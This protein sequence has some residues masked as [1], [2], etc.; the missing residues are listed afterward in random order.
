MPSLDVSNLLDTWLEEAEDE[1]HNLGRMRT[2]TIATLFGARL[3]TEPDL[4]SSRPWWDILYDVPHPV[5]EP[6]QAPRQAFIVGRSLAKNLLPAIQ[7][8]NFMF[9]EWCAAAKTR[10]QTAGSPPFDVLE[11]DRCVRVIDDLDRLSRV[12]PYFKWLNEESPEVTE[13]TQQIHNLLECF[14][15]SGRLFVAG[16][17]RLEA[18]RA[19]F[20]ESVYSRDILRHIAQH[21]EAE[22]LPPIDRE[23]YRSTWWI[24]RCF[25]GAHWQQIEEATAGLLDEL[26]EEV[27]PYPGDESES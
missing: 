1:V 27:L 11:V 2:A 13:A 26:D 9:E 20:R 14:S 17:H 18:I 15:R 12:L 5:D 21:R 22:T 23:V 10:L 6:P 7:A 25:A 3:R 4:L 24:G 19:T 16:I 8:S